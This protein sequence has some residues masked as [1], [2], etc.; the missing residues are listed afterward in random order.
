MFVQFSEGP[1]TG[2]AIKDLMTGEI[3]LNHMT[4]QATSN[5]L[6]A[7]EYGP[8]GGTSEC[9]E[10]AAR[11]KKR[12]VLRAKSHAKVVDALAETLRALEAHIAAIAAE[13]NLKDASM[14]C[15]CWDN[16]VQ[17]ARAALKLA[18]GEA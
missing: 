6:Y 18:R 7:L 11:I 15:P 4:Y 12:I 5:V 13:A 16:E 3:V 9:D 8:G 10:I 14:V 2:W 17:R 1:A